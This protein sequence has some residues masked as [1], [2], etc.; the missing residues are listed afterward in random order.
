M[1]ES[2]GLGAI[3]S[4]SING[5]ILVGME[6]NAEKKVTRYNKEGRKL[7]GIQW[8][9]Q[10]QSLYQRIDY[11]TEN[12]NGDICSSDSSAGRV[13]VVTA[14]GE[15]RFSYYGLHR[16]SYSGRHS[17]SRF[18]PFGICTDVLG[19]I[20]ICN[21]SDVHLLDINGQFLS[22]LLVKDQCPKSSC[23]LCIDDEHNFWIG[24]S[25][26]STVSVY[27]YLKKTKQYFI[28]GIHRFESQ[29]LLA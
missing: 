14:S 18:C 12:I 25:D 2:W 3:F 29:P 16:F 27:K 23:G 10:G 8:G 9:D 19:Q 5:H 7:Q 17:Q 15:Y 21:Y 11:I 13:V 28:Y 20:L 1:T 6:R 26:S 4:S 24:A 22:F